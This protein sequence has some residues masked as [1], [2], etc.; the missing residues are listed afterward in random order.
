MGAAA[1]GPCRCVARASAGAVCRYTG[2]YTA[3]QVHM[4]AHGCALRTCKCACACARAPAGHLHVRVGMWAGILE[5]ECAGTHVD[6]AMHKVN[7][8]L[9]VG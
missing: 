3:A 2:G 6:E 7:W 8:R 9:S 4:R 1:C 5:Q